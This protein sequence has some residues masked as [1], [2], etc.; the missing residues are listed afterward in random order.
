MTEGMIGEGCLLSS[1]AR[2]FETA[3]PVSSV[4]SG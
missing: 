4:A 3:E 1:D 2:M